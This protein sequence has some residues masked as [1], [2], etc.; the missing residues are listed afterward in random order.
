MHT[1][2]LRGVKKQ[3]IYKIV[4]A[5][6]FSV[7]SKCEQRSPSKPD[8]GRTS[9]SVRRQI[10]GLCFDLVK[11]RWGNIRPTKA[12]LKADKGGVPIG[13]YRETRAVLNW[14]STMTFGWSKRRPL[15]VFGNKLKVTLL[16]LLKI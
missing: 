6:F 9:S 10:F 14:W 16:N 13:V 11:V 1:P 5:N 4:N 8:D 12:L 3:D 15:C 2:P 7:P